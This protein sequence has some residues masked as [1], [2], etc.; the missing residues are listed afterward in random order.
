[1]KKLRGEAEAGTPVTTLWDLIGCTSCGEASPP[2]DF[3][4]V[5]RSV[6][7]LRGGFNWL[8]EVKQ[9]PVRDEIMPSP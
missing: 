6:L 7:D 8:P 3:T 5:G 1:M 4:A 9:T 2:D